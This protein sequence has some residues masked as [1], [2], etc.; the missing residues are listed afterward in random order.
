MV[1]CLSQSPGFWPP[2]RPRTWGSRFSFVLGVRCSCATS[3]A[4][5]NASVSLSLR[6]GGIFF[7]FAGRY[8]GL[9]VKIL[10]GSFM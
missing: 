7:K 10:Q 4:F 8:K 2:K 6:Q 1:R 9:L 5:E 3:S